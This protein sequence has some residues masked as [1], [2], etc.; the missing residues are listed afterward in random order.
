MFFSIS[1]WY[2][3]IVAVGQGDQQGNWFWSESYSTYN[4]HCLEMGTKICYTLK[5]LCYGWQQ[6]A[7]W[8]KDWTLTVSSNYVKIPK[9]KET[10]KQLEKALKEN[11]QLKKS[12][13]QLKSK[14]LKLSNAVKKCKEAGYN[15]TRAQT[16]HKL[17]FQCSEWRQWNL[18]QK[19]KQSCVRSL[20]WLEQRNIVHQRLK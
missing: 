15:P 9:E 12:H 6:A 10:E 2:D 16:L 11:A 3:H 20:V 4:G 7:F 19:R 13:D 17:P 8:S 18:K 1:S 5:T 14:V